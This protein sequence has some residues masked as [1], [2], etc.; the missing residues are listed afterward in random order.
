MG[1][2]S[3]RNGD[4]SYQ[5]RL[6]AGGRMTIAK[7][8]PFGKQL[9]H[10]IDRLSE[11]SK[12]GRMFRGVRCLLFCGART[13]KGYGKIQVA[14]RSVFAHRAAFVWAHKAQ[15]PDGQVIDHL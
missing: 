15:I 7:S 4:K 14:G 11:K 8:I 9:D 5:R 10:A 13:P 6:C 1:R 12:P 3:E 2:E